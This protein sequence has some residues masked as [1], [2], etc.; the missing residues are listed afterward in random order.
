[1]V[2]EAQH[3]VGRKETLLAAGDAARGRQH[4][5][6]ELPYFA[7]ATHSIWQGSTESIR[8]HIS[9]VAVFPYATTKSCYSE[10]SGRGV[11]K[12]NQILLTCFCNVNVSI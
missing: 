12:L 4:A 11:S 7:L 9:C 2:G 10:A 6:G 1:M 5:S 8:A 3:I